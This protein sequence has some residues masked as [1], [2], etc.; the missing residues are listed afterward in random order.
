MQARVLAESTARLNIAWGP[1]RSGKTVGLELYRWLEYVQQAPDGDL[2]MAA[3]TL[4]TLERNVLRPMQDTFGGSVVKYS[5]GKKQARIGGRRVELEG[6]NDAQA[7]N[8][9]RG[10]TLAGACI[11]EITL[12]PESFFKQI[13]ARMSVAGAKL[14][15]TT[16]PDSSY[17]WLKTDFLDR[18]GELDLRQ[19]KFSLDD[20]IFL[21]EDY[22]SALKAEYTGL[23]HRRF[24]LGL[25]VQAAGAVY[26]HFD[27]DTH[28][29]ELP[30]EKCRRVRQWIVD[31]DYGT[32]NPTTF[33]LKG[34]W[35][36]DVG[37]E[38]KPFAH[39]F[40]EYHHDGRREGQKTDEEYAAAMEVFVPEAAGGQ[41]LPEKRGAVPI[42][43]D[44]AAASFIVALQQKG[45]RV[46]SADNSVL[47]GIRFVASMLGGRDDAGEW[48]RYTI[49][50]SCTETPRSYA[51][52][53]WDEKAQDRGED[54]PLKQQDHCVDRD[55]YGL[56]THLG[57]KKRTLR[58]AD[59]AL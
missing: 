45:F 25:W 5:L 44:P 31:V 7:E 24:I 18:E 39:T 46:V 16:N 41:A 3:K 33:S 56:Y 4:K 8:K 17:H 30:P 29:Q 57:K 1:V 51:A 10:M 34:V 59:A 11:N 21:D 54:Q 38:R 49:D 28:V 15:G 42:Y 35:H 23:W 37:G 52:Y 58:T 50:P 53:V 48:P 36:E 9:I 32:S 6:G 14:F 27:D 12:V 43:V 47:D 26:A 20:N 2:L 19:W 22:V 55:R 40:K 13:L